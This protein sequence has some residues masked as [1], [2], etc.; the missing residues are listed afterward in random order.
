MLNKIELFSIVMDNPAIYYAG[1]T[2]KGVVKLKLTEKLSL[3]G[4]SLHIEGIAKVGWTEPQSFHDR[5]NIR[6]SDTNAFFNVKF[7]L[8]AVQTETE[9]LI[10]LSSGEYEY[11]FLTILPSNLPSSFDGSFGQ[12]YY[13]CNCQIDVPLK[14]DPRCKT[15]FTVIQL[16]DLNLFPNINIPCTKRNKHITKRCCMNTGAI[17][18][19]MTLRK[20]GYVCGENIHVKV[21]VS[22]SS[23][24]AIKHISVALIQAITYRTGLHSKGQPKDICSVR[25]SL[26]ESDKLGCTFNLTLHIPAVPPTRSTSGDK[27]LSWEYLIEVSNYYI[28]ITRNYW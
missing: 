19:S 9:D 14:Y 20:Q 1:Q 5:N 7:P 17:S 6:R 18:A 28:Y 22:N 23:G 8:L 13:T 10:D 12:I 21:E 3:K 11:P 27:L 4:I 26:A 24:K 15:T 25:H 2:V 16:V